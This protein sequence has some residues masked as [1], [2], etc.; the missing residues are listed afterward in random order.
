MARRIHQHRN[1]DR[2]AGPWSRPRALNRSHSAVL[3]GALLVAACSLLTLAHASPAAAGERGS[4]GSPAPLDI[5]RRALAAE[6]TTNVRGK[7]LAFI[8]PP[9]LAAVTMERDV[10]RSKDGRTL[11]RWVGPAS[12]RGTII[13]DDGK[14]TRTYVPSTKELTTMR[15]APE[16]RDKAS[17]ARRARMIANNYTLRLVDKEKVAGRLCYV[18]TLT[19]KSEIAHPIRLWIDTKNYYI[20]SRQESNDRGHTIALTL[21]RWVEFPA[22]IA[23]SALAHPFPAKPKTVKPLPS[24]VFRTVADLR[25]SLSRDVCVPVSMPGG[26]AFERCELIKTGATSMACLR[27]SDG[28]SAISIYQWAP[29]RRPDEPRPPW[30]TMNY[31]RTPMGE[32][33]IDYTTR[34]LNF[35]LI[36]RVEM[37]G[38]VCIANALNPARESAYLSQT[39]KDYR[40]PLDTLNG[41]RS[42]GLGLDT[43]NAVLAI[44]AHSRKP[45]SSLVSLIRQGYCWRE[46]ARRFRLDTPRFAARVR[47]FECR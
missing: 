2:E 42:Q 6:H 7:E 33:A 22:S 31:S 38:L 26:F 3:P 36:G 4:G 11:F 16:P 28:W 15:S 34:D 1:E 44:S 35:T 23:A 41:M 46:L 32:C 27:Y 18:V 5:V 24:R 40:V 12:K 19:P 21:F 37:A 13:L 8:E 47:F 29:E 30:R 9:G 25:R 45:V 39:A 43:I 14:W 20:I 17:V 10:T